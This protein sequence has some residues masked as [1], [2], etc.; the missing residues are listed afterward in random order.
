ML[1]MTHAAAECSVR[2]KADTTE[3][4]APPRLAPRLRRP[5]RAQER[6]NLADGQRNPLLRLLPREHADLR[7]RREHRG[8]HRDGVRMRRDVVREN[9]DGCL[10]RA[11]EVAR[12]GEDEVG[13]R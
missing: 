9:Q 7:I 12:D 13:V 2:L 10:A 5:V 8:F 1:D 11:H 6:A 3:S 4:Y